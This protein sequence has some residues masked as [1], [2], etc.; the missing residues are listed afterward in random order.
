[1]VD[2]SLFDFAQTGAF[3]GIAVG[4]ERPRVEAILGRPNDWGI[5]PA[6]IETAEIWK[7]GD[8]EFYFHDHELWMIF[9]DSF[10]VPSGGPSISLDPWTVRYGMSRQAFENAL[11]ASRIGFTTGKTPPVR[12]AS[13]SPVEQSAHVLRSDR[14]REPATNCRRRFPVA[15]RVGRGVNSTRELKNPGSERHSP[16]P[17]FSSTEFYPARRES[18]LAWKSGT[19]AGGIDFFTFREFTHVT[20]C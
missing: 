1:M 18:V 5:A 15:N 11:R 4:D 3:G 7:Y 8:I 6:P 20:V 10:D 19:A 14:V 2:A 13:G 9:T 16:A 17:R 12:A